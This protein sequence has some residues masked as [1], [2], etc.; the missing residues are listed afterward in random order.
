MASWDSPAVPAPGAANY[1]AP[2]VNFDAIANLPKDY[3][4][5]K[6]MVYKSRE[7]QRQEDQATAFRTGIPKDNTGN[8]DYLSMANDMLKLGNYS[9]AAEFQKTGIEMQRMRNGQGISNQYLSPAGAGAAPSG[10][11]TAPARTT[12]AQDTAPSAPGGQLPTIRQILQARRT[13]PTINGTR[14]RP[15]L[16]AS[17]ASRTMPGSTRTILRFETF[18]DPRLAF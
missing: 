1:A 12:S 10:Q 6:E 11:P 3:Y 16:D 2:L 18:L 4:A 8:P 17:L 9:Q 7:M 14:R 5:G 15:G 13:S